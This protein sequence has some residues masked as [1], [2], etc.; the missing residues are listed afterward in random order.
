LQATRV[1]TAAKAIKNFFILNG[2]LFDFGAK[3]QNNC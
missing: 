1:I 2:C 3:I